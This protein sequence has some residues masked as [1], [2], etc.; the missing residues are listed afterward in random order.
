MTVNM[1]RNT[2]SRVIRSG[3]Y[4][5]AILVTNLLTISSLVDAAGLYFLQ[6]FREH[7]I[8]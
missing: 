6:Q 7:G 4:G 3:H 8:V 1:G 2:C 5:M